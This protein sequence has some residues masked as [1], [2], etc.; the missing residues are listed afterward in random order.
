MKRST[1]IPVCFATLLFACGNP[2]ENNTEIKDS[3]N[4]SRMDNTNNT[5]GTSDTLRN[6][7]N[8]N[9]ESTNTRVATDEAAT[10]FLKE[11][12]DVGM[13]EVQ[14]GQLAQDKAN[15][16][17]VK[18]FG[19]MMIHDHSAANDQ[20][21]QL[22]AQRN[23]TLPGDLSSQHQNTKASLMKKQGSAFDK[24]YI[25][26]MVK[27]HQDAIKKFETTLDNT[28]DQQVKDFINNTLPTLK[29]HLD[30]AK[31]IQKKVIR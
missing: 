26:D 16:Q 9:P 21:K 30:S 10:S 4:V 23:L 22:A 14:L 1:I 31:A 15:N 7:M 8:V 11:V 29:M 18:D 3:T 12:A 24:A 27:G 28:H 13:T 5:S 6:S 17:R 2:S 25:D 20:V 19:T